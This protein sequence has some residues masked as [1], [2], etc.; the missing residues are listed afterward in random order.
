MAEAKKGKS[1]K[2]TVEWLKDLGKVSKGVEAEMHRT[3]AEA[4]KSSGYVK[5]TGDAKVEILESNKA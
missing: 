1:P 2:V 4:L 5:I 3:T